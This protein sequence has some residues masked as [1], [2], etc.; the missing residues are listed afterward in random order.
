MAGGKG[1]NR[2]KRK[3]KRGRR[4]DYNNTGIKSGGIIPN[5][6]VSVPLQPSGEERGPSSDPRRKKGQRKSMGRK[7]IGGRRISLRSL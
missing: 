5:R 1:K 6:E 7:K 2:R 3:K 4:S